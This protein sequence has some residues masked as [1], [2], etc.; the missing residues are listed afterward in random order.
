MRTVI[1]LALLVSPRIAGAQEAGG[2]SDSQWLLADTRPYAAAIGLQDL[3]TAS[4]RGVLHEVR[5][6]TGFGLTGVALLVLRETA[7][8]WTGADYYPVGQARAPKRLRLPPDSTQ[9]LWRA[10][11]DAGLRQLP[12]EPQRVPSTLFVDDGYSVLIE[13]ADSTRTGVTAAVH[14]DVFCSADDERILAVVRALVGRYAPT[15]VAH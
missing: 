3:A 15:C 1:L 11:V 9:K 7:K 14:P 6:W 8:G 12:I 4:Q 5:L 13:W 10:A 2:A